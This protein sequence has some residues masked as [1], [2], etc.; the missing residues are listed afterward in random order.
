M[1]LNFSFGNIAAGLVFSGIGFVA[2]TF[3][4]KTGQFKLMALGGVLMVFSYFT[5]STALTCLVGAALTAGLY[6]A[7]E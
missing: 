6:Y 5:P 3:G 4:K 1:G 2:F 7:R